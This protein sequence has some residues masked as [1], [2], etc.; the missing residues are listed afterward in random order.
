MTRVDPAAAS[1]FYERN[2]YFVFRNV[3]SRDAIRSVHECLEQEVY[4]SD[5]ALLRH[6]SVTKQPH[7]YRTFGDGTKFVSNALYNPHCEP[8]TAHLGQLIVQ[9]VCGDETAACLEML[10]G[11]PMHTMH[12]AI[13]FFVPPGTGTH[14]DG[15]AL[16]TFPPGNFMTMWVPL[17]TI[18]L[19][20]GPVAVFP[21]KR[22]K[23]L[24][25]EMLGVDLSN[26]EN[27]A[28]YF[29]YTEAL[30]RSVHESGISCVVPQLEPGDFI[31]FSSLTPHATMPAKNEH[32]RRMALQILVRPTASRWGGI[33]MSRL[34]GEGQDGDPAETL[35]VSKRWHAVSASA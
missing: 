22:G 21:W 4:P 33:L 11:E 3:L 20:N 26:K 32:L 14:I 5:A 10:D 15:W 24:T 8:E 1:D 2:G 18:T 27:Q 19:H 7:E 17:E 30:V 31:V 13:L 25:P 35:S 34:K 6:P 29:T 16:D 9:L 23:F 12:Q 28:A